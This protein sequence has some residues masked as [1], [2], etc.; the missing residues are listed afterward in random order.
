MVPSETDISEKLLHQLLWLGRAL[1]MNV[2]TSPTGH[3]FFDR[4]GKFVFKKKL[5]RNFQTSDVHH[6]RDSDFQKPTCSHPGAPARSEFPVRCL[7][8]LLSI[9]H[10]VL[11]SHTEIDV[12]PAL[13][14]VWQCL[15][16]SVVPGVAIQNDSECPGGRQCDHRGDIEK[17]RIFCRCR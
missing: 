3:L 7:V 15:W 14:R 6:I 8:L 17:T 5:D 16:V 9:L 4:L 11:A 13:V 10:W 2:S 1:K 12:S